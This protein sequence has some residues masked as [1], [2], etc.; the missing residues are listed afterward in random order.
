MLLMILMLIAIVVI[1]AR[2]VLIAISTAIA[3]ISIVA[4]AV[5]SISVVT[6]AVASISVV[7]FAT[8]T[9][10]E[11]LSEVRIEAI[12]LVVAI[13]IDLSGHDNEIA[14]VASWLEVLVIVAV[15]I[16]VWIDN[17]VLLLEILVQR[18]VFALAE[19]CL[20]AAFLHAVVAV[21]AAVTASLL[22]A[23]V[24]AH[25][26]IIAIATTSHLHINRILP[27]RA[28][29]A[30]IVCPNLEFSVAIHARVESLGDFVWKRSDLLVQQLADTRLFFAVQKPIDGLEDLQASRLFGLVDDRDGVFVLSDD[31]FK[32]VLVVEVTSLGIFQNAASAFMITELEDFTRDSLI[33]GGIIGQRNRCLFCLIVEHSLGGVWNIGQFEDVDVEKLID[34]G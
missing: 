20:F 26:V 2:V 29:L 22:I 7:A 17:D 27:S 24:L 28:L 10:I 30:S 15:I 1:T 5:T 33:F 32:V 19:H 3:T 16:G 25:P 4:F 21:V 6:F 13:S 34:D 14:K 8:R 11:A 12:A 23:V 18:I 9:L 31:L